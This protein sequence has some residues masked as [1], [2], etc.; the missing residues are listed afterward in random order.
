MHVITSRSNGGTEKC[1]DG[2]TATAPVAA[3]LT[4]TPT[5]P[6]QQTKPD[7]DAI[8][9][10]LS[11]SAESTRATSTDSERGRQEDAPTA[12]AA[13]SD[14]PDSRLPTREVTQV[15]APSPQLQAT[16][17]QSVLGEPQRSPSSPTTIDLSPRTDGS[18]LSRTRRSSVCRVTPAAMA[19]MRRASDPNRRAS[20]SPAV[21]EVATAFETPLAAR[22][23]SQDTLKIGRS[24]ESQGEEN[25][26]APLLYFLTTIAGMSA[27]LASFVYVLSALLSRR[28][29]GSVATCSTLA[30]DEYALRLH[31]S[32]NHSVDPCQ[33]FTHFVCDGWRKRH[34]FAVN[35][36][37][38]G[39]D[40]E[41][42]AHIA[43]TIDV[44]PTGQSMLQRGAMIYRCALWASP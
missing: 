31:A 12:A 30:C 26:V 33:S 23:S 40:I 41:R 14:S 25:T 21:L 13:G 1:T 6:A 8:T 9:Q 16:D 18:V 42:I 36:E 32:L 2:T 34:L 5:E 11:L 43:A 28:E 20:L 10:Q 38:F 17:A 7:S 22:R 4:V 24:R 29:A 37:A 44:P 3:T 27:V 39:V 15:S 19:A 35:E